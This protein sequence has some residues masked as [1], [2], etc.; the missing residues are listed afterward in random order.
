MRAQE[1]QKEVDMAVPRE[2][3]LR[4]MG[5]V[6]KVLKEARQLLD[7]RQEFSDFPEI[8][9]YF[10]GIFDIENAINKRISEIRRQK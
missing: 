2:D 1:T 6:L 4:R 3:Q 9:E 10:N 7:V 8:D 5:I